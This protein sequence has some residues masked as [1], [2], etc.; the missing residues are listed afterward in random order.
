MRGIHPPEFANTDRAMQPGSSSPF[1]SSVLYMCMDNC[2]W[3]TSSLVSGFPA[4]H[5]ID[6]SSGNY[7]FGDNLS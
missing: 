6:P 1:A 4:T 2:A 3:C 5:Y 7:M